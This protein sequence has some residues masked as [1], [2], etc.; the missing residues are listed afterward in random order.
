MLVSA[1]GNLSIHLFQRHIKSIRKRINYE[2][3]AR[4]IYT[5]ALINYT[6]RAYTAKFALIAPERRLEILKIDEWKELM[7]NGFDVIVVPGGHYDI[8]REPNIQIMA[9]KIKPY[10]DIT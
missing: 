5:K 4:H 6:P 3:D 10:L 2:D 9:G 7:P 8:W 1:I